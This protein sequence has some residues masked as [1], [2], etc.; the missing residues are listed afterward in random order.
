MDNNL[1]P[2]LIDSSDSGKPVAILFLYSP[3]IYGT[4]V[5]RPYV[6]SFSN[7]AVDKL[8]GAAPTMTEAFRRPDIAST[9]EVASCIK[10]DACGIGL[11]MDV[12]SMMWTF[13]LFVR[14]PN[15]YNGV[16]LKANGF[17][18][19]I[20]TGQC[21][22]EPVGP[23]GS[24]NPDCRLM[25]HSRQVMNARKIGSSMGARLDAKAFPP[26]SHPFWQK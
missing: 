20:M 26:P 19:A 9:E 21:L 4:Q 24:I 23:M 15:N 13:L 6:Y 11:N 2:F 22:D 10:P 5:L 3:R 12:A 14:Q 25:V 18:T 16:A 17:N 8:L 1:N 7:E